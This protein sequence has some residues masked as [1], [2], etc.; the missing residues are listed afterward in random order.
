MG[1]AWIKDRKKD[2][3]Y[4][5]AKREKFR[6]RASFKLLQIQEKFRI[7]DEGFKVL[8]LGASPGGWSQV[9]R[10]LVGERG[11]VYAVDIVRMAPIERVEFLRGDLRDPSFVEEIIKKSGS[12]DVVLS[13]M[14][15]KLSGTKSYDQARVME[16]ASI[17][18][19]MA[20]RCLKVGGN[21]VSKAFR[22]IDFDDFLRKVSGHFEMTK[23]YTPPAS[24]KGSAEV[25]IVGKNFRR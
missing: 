25:Y 8:D 2:P 23:V 6:S 13:D 19:D 12:V 5:A 21:F 10:N 9:V 18:L 4:R 22:G 3:Y 7:I 11:E 14:A 16:L 1:K 15:P 17:A 24:T 20:V